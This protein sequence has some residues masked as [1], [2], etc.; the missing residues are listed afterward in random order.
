MKVLS[1]DPE[2][3]ERIQKR[4]QERDATPARMRQLRIAAEAQAAKDIEA[5]KRAKTTRQ[6]YEKLEKALAFYES[7]Y[8]LMAPRL[9]TQRGNNSLQK[10]I[11][12]A[13][14]LM[15]ISRMP[16]STKR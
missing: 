13:L 6:F 8:C 12:N 3:Y 2:Y 10:Q 11:A 15:A 7:W 1:L 9:A 16:A 4:I 5:Q 14:L